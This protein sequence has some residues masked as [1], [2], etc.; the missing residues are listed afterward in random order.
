M[1]SARVTRGAAS[2]RFVGYLVRHAGEVQTAEDGPT[3][4]KEAQQKGSVSMSELETAGRGALSADETAQ[5]E[6]CEATI[7]AGL[8]TFYEVGTALLTI[9]EARLYRRDFATF[10]DYCRQR[11]HMVASRARQLIGAAQVVANIESVT[12]VTPENERQARE[13]AAV[14]AGEQQTVWDFAVKAAP[15]VDDKPVITAQHIKKAAYTVALLKQHGWQGDVQ[16]GRALLIDA[17]FHARTPDVPPWLFDSMAESMLRFGIINPLD[18]WGNTIVDGHV[19]Y[20]IAMFYGLSF[21]TMPRHFEQREDVLTFIRES[22]VHR[23]PYTLAEL[24]KIYAETKDAGLLPF[25]QHAEEAQ[26]REE[27]SVH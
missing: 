21:E 17:E 20:F 24:N 6:T 8:Q 14:A 7:K 4:N 18:V 19:R 10:E 15:V 13:L 25:I 16:P 3:D 12:T 2:W 26:A 5:L 22:H 11:W 27:G 23:K 9:R 1:V